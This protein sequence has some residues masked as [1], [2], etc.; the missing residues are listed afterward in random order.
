MVKKKMA[1]ELRAEEKEQKA[2]DARELEKQ[3]QQQMAQAQR[4]RALMSMQR[5][6]AP[7]MGNVVGPPGQ[8]GCNQP[9]QG[10]KGKGKGPRMVGG[11]HLPRNRILAS[12][13]YGEVIEWLGKYGW[14]KPMEPV[15]HPLAHKHNGRIYVSNKDL[16]NATALQQGQLVAFYVYADASGLGAEDVLSA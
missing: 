2:K 9:Y 6:A 14:V 5:G 10:F 1:W 8:P 3:L 12:T 4:S 16:T 15:D 7:N 11:P 13:V